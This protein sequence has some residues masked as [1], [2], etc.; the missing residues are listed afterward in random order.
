M[1]CCSRDA[2]S[3]LVIVAIAVATY[4]HLPRSGDIAWYDASGHALNGALIFDFFR[5][6]A[7]A[8][9]MAFASSY[10]RQWPALT[11]GFYPPLFSIVLALSYAVFGVSEAAAL[12]P[13]AIF[14]MLLGWGAY[15]LSCRWLPV[16]SALATAI[17][18]MGAPELF[19]WA[20]QIMLDIPSYAF[21]VWA[22]EFH[23]R[24]LDGKSRNSLYIS[25]FLA[26][27][28]A[29]TKYNAVIILPVL[30][31]SMLVELR[32]ELFRKKHWR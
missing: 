13:E 4:F 19:F 32:F 28:A 18:V 2:W 25:V 21:I 20:Q 30:A 15:R 27:M 14:Y 17:M 11:I 23:F 9:P 8:H 3:L 12:V 26:L 22:V 7:W 29:Y 24:Y 1:R 6:G 31:I 5:S 16:P 10:Y